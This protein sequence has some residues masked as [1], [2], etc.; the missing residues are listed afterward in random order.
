MGG[1]LRTESF[2][3][4]R[5]FASSPPANSGIVNYA[6]KSR[7]KWGRREYSIYKWCKI[8]F[9]SLPPPSIM[10][11]ISPLPTYGRIQRHQVHRVSSMHDIS[12]QCTYPGN[13]VPDWPGSSM[14]YNMLRP[15]F[16][17]ILSDVSRATCEKQGRIRRHYITSSAGLQGCGH[18][19]L[20]L[21]TLLTAPCGVACIDLQL[22][23]G[24]DNGRSTS[25]PSTSAERRTCHQPVRR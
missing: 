12:A 21:A 16:S 3:Q 17:A 14:V 6:V 2:Q 1:A 4:N 9:M 18:Q 15:A 23:A 20:I 10:T 11:E 25:A 24:H 13:V 7:Y 22:S 8:D 19:S 5:Y